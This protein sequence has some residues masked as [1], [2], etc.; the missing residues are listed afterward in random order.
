MQ[1]RHTPENGTVFA[2]DYSH[3]KAVCDTLRGIDD[4]ER[5]GSLEYQ[6][7]KKRSS[8][9]ARNMVILIHLAAV[10]LFSTLTAHMLDVMTGCLVI[11]VLQNIWRRTSCSLQYPSPS[12]SAHSCYESDSL[13]KLFDLISTQVQGGHNGNCYTI[14]RNILES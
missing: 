7:V 4:H 14:A 11:P 10:C 6:L 8:V 12:K 13:L 1:Q 3:I 9:C 2:S 5:E